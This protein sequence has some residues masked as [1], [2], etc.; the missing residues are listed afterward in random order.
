MVAPGQNIVRNYELDFAQKI[1]VHKS[2]LGRAF[3]PVARRGNFVRLAETILCGLQSRMLS[4]L[5]SKLR[6]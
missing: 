1:S 5:L 2:L 3:Q 6:V 4:Y